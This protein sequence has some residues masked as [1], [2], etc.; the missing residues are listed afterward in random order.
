MVH[1]EVVA[2]QEV[3]VQVEHQQKVHQEQAVRVGVMV[4][5]AQVEVRE[6]T[7]QA[8]LLVQAAPAE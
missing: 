4:Q 7:E 2:H 1:L 6:L 8:E 3:R 5:A